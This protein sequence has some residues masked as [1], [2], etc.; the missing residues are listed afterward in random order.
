MQI[1]LISTPSI[2]FDLPACSSRLHYTCFFPRYFQ[3]HDVTRQIF[4]GFPFWF[5][6]GITRIFLVQV[7]RIVIISNKHGIYELPHEL[8]N[9]LRLRTLGNYEI[10]RRCQNI[11]NCSLVLNL[12]PKIRILSILAKKF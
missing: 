6:I 1:L 5:S 9:D 7:K 8:P 10:S 3:F 11:K 2:Q 4:I 12:A